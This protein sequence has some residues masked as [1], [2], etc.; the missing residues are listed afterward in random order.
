MATDYHG[1]NPIAASPDFDVST[2]LIP[3]EDGLLSATPLSD[4][5]QF[6]SR[7]D[8]DER[9][10]QENLLRL[11][12]PPL[13]NN[14]AHPARGALQRSS[15]PISVLTIPPSQHIQYRWPTPPGA[16]RAEGVEDRVQSQGAID[17][18]NNSYEFVNPQTP[19]DSDA[20][21]RPS[22]VTTLPLPGQQPNGQRYGHISQRLTEAFARRP[23]LSPVQCTFGHMTVREK[24]IHF[25]S[26]EYDALDVS[27]FR[28]QFEHLA[29]KSTGLLLL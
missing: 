15:S 14:F 19:P 25:E 16:R 8:E 21:F 20:F 9:R 29:S 2:G 13:F 7:L 12:Q 1:T 4:Y 3:V 28:V 5:I 18:S 10:L 11:L 26:G 23:M 6:E 22:Q 24:L 27:Q 17:N